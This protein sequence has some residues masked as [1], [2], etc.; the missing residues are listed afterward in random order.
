MGKPIFSDNDI[1][2]LYSLIEIPDYSSIKISESNDYARYAKTLLKNFS[3]QAKNENVERLGRF[4]A[5]CVKA[6]KKNIISLAEAASILYKNKVSLDSGIATTQQFIKRRRIEEENKFVKGD[7]LDE[8]SN[9]AKRF[10]GKVKLLGTRGF[11]TAWFSA[12][13]YRPDIIFT[14][15]EARKAR[16]KVYY[17][18]PVFMVPKDTFEFLKRQYEYFEDGFDEYIQYLMFLIEEQRKRVNPG[19][20]ADRTIYLVT[21]A[22][23]IN[24]VNPNNN[25]LAINTYGHDRPTYKGLPEFLTLYDVKTEKEKQEPAA[26]QMAAMKNR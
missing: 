25:L 15:D 11:K 19:F 13:K 17:E 12:V 18:K 4:I 8:L 6:N 20:V 7:S 24:Q 22:T 16:I 10:H 1:K 14:D 5:R 2:T 9:E 26:P 21:S 23:N 3:I